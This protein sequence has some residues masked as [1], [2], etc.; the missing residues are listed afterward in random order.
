MSNSPSIT[1]SSQEE[2]TQVTVKI[3]HDDSEHDP[4]TINF[5]VREINAAAFEKQLWNIVD[6]LRET[7]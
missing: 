3:G 2:L 1:T 4:T 5:K 7:E 6:K